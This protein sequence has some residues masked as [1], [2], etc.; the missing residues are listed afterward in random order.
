MYHTFEPLAFAS[1]QFSLRMM[2]HLLASFTL[3]YI[4][5]VCVGV[6][7]GRYAKRDASRFARILSPSTAPTSHKPSLVTACITP[8]VILFII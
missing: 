3:R 1:F 2:D 5:F 4:S 7:G 8:A 6:A